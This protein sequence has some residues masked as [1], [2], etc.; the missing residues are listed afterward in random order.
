LESK[1]QGRKACSICRSQ[2]FQRQEKAASVRPE[3]T[4]GSIDTCHNLPRHGTRDAWLHLQT[5]SD[6]FSALGAAMN[7]VT[8]PPAA[9]SSA[10]SHDLSDNELAD[11]VKKDVADKQFL[12]MADM[13][14]SIH[15]D[16]A[17]FQ[18]QSSLRC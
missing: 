7:A 17:T 9:S 6:F 2:L 16:R 3:K 14:P 15:D 10:K 18:S 1:T 11:V 5:F 8:R 12:V 13:T 4:T